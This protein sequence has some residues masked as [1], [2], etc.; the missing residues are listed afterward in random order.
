MFSPDNVFTLINAAILPFWLLLLVA[1]HAK[2]TNVLVHSGLVAVL[3][4]AVY[5]YYVGTS[6]VGGGLEEGSMSSLQGLLIAFSDPGAV[7]GA[8]THYLVFDL[9]VGAWIVRDAKREQIHHMAIVVPIIFTLMLGPVGI[10][11]YV[12]IRGIMR[13]RFSFVESREPIVA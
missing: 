2:V 10:L 5:I 13:K 1:P 9:F 4:G 8:W 6:F 3:F 7:V 12:V 11:L